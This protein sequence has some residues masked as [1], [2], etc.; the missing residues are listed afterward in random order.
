GS[1]L[2]TVTTNY[3]YDAYGN[4]TIVTTSTP[5]GA[6][7]TTI[8]FYRND[9]S[10]WIL[11]RLLATAATGRVPGAPSVTQS[12][13]FDYDASGALIQQTVEPN[14]PVPLTTS[15]GLDAFGNRTS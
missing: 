1:P 14:S 3:Q 15:F 6:T 8:Q 13:M 7:N 2:P 11:G 10:N 12:S 4:P 9:T 5:D